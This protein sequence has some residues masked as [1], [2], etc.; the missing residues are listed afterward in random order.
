VKKPRSFKARRDDLHAFIRRDLRRHP[1]M[2]HR[3]R[4]LEVAETKAQKLT[5]P[6]N[7]WDGK[8]PTEC[9]VMAAE[10]YRCLSPS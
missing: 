5:A 6:Q 3:L 9:D 8:C 4:G 10:G 2:E 7:R 1:D